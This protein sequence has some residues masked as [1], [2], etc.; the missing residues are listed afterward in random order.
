LRLR[1]GV[2]GFAGVQS[3]V[4]IPDIARNGRFRTI[5]TPAPG[6]GTVHYWFSVSTLR[7]ADYAFAPGSSK[8]IR[9]IVR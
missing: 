4:G 5:W 9:V 6:N 2:V 3:T 7:E 1:I 8:K